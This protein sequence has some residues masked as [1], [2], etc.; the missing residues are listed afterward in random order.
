MDN[1]YKICIVGES[2]SGKTSIIKRYV[3][4]IFS[5]HYKE[6]ID[7]EF[8]TKK[9]NDDTFQLCDI[10][11]K[12]QGTQTNEYYKDSDAAFIVV[13]STDKYAI[14]SVV[15]WKK[16]ID[17]KI[18]CPIILLINKTD[19]N[20]K[21]Y[22]ETREALCGIYHKLDCVCISAK[23]NIG[24]KDA[25]DKMFTLVKKNKEQLRCEN[26]SKE[27]KNI[28]SADKFLS[29][30]FD[31]VMRDK[32]I[33]NME[34]LSNLHSQQIIMTLKMKFINLYYSQSDDMKLIREEIKK[35]D[36]LKRIVIGV[37]DIL[38]M[39]TITDNTKI[40]HIINLIMRIGLSMCE[41]N[42]Y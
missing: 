40:E 4:G 16:D 6:T 26:K 39:D 32:Y 31:C 24:I 19:I 23:N 25:F 29:V 1:S 10:G 7:V 36:L 14:G 12:H 18:G 2:R 22:E 3:H 27:V 11:S 42:S 30:F 9:L 38:L 35:N 21:K 33:K 8:T 20:D 13:D 17:A 37:H 15:Y 5:E 41:Q 28:I 34:T